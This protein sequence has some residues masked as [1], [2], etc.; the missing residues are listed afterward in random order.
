MLNL[1]MAARTACEPHPCAD[2]TSRMN[3]PPRFVG[4][5]PAVIAI[6]S[7]IAMPL[8]CHGMTAQ[9]THSHFEK[10]C[11]VSTV[12]PIGPGFHGA[13]GPRVFAGGRITVGA[14]NLERLIQL[15]Y[16]VQSFQIS[17]GPEWKD[18][19]AF[20]VVALCPALPMGAMPSKGYRYTFTESERAVLRDL[21]ES[22]FHLRVRH[23]TVKGPAFSLIKATGSSALS[24]TSK[25]DREPAASVMQKGSKIDGEA[26]GI[27][28][29]MDDVAQEFTTDLQRIVINKTGITGSYDFHV[30][31]F[32]EENT[33][34]EFA[35]RGVA[36]R[37]GLELKKGISAYD[38]LVIESVTMP[39]AN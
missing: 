35:V 6:F 2:K 11:E 29:S 14:W 20:D 25:A 24:P 38:S 5:R 9:E 12:K 39:D 13:M 36:K 3:G 30:E 7:I 1:R 4:V 26:F 16:S 17:G 34:I 15:A 27:N 18:K 22:R 28:A 19:T 37:L 21:L 8:I 23:T 33:D 10:E 32:D 31:P